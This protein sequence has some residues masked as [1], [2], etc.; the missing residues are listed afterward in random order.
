MPLALTL[1]API[2]VGMAYFHA[3][4]AP[5]GIS[6]ALVFVAMELVLAWSYRDAFSPMLRAW[7]S[8]VAPVARGELRAIEPAAR[9][10]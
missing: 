6:P 10:G 1:L 9:A 8:P 5:A 3:M 4:L 2:L 7:V